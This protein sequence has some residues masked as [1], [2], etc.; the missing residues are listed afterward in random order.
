MPSFKPSNFTEG[1][2]LWEGRGKIEAVK[3]VLWDY[4]GKRAV[5]IPAAAVTISAEDLDT[6]ITQYYSAGRPEDWQPSQDGK[7]FVAV[8]KAESINSTCN[9]ALFLAP[10]VNAGF[11][12]DLLDK[13]DLTVMV[14]LDAEFKWVAGP[15]RTFK[16]AG[17]AEETKKSDILVVKKVYALPGEG[18]EKPKKKGKKGS[19]KGGDDMSAKATAA[20]LGILA[21]GEEVA[22]KDLP[23]LIFEHL[24]DDPDRNA[25]LAMA[26]DEGFLGDGPWSYTDGVL[27]A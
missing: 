9:L 20:I 5:A 26:F 15:E 27:T 25:V 12:E 10:L 8:G 22:K 24:G 16:R 18:E 2:G 7:T 21:A 17:G 14:G 13:D 23:K 11:P 6:P 4:N 1:G 3:A 19:S